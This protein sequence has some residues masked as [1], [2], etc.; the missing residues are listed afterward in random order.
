MWFGVSLLSCYQQL[1]KL[2]R[3]RRRKQCLQLKIGSLIVEHS[4]S[5]QETTIGPNQ[6]IEQRNWIPSPNWIHARMN[7]SAVRELQMSSAFNSRWAT[8]SSHLYPFAT[9]GSKKEP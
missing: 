6:T 8:Q 9:P 7:P 4:T 3:R 5:R 2:L 1:L